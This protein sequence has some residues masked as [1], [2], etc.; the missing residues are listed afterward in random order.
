MVDDTD[1][2]IASINWRR[3]EIFPQTEIDFMREC[4]E[5]NDYDNKRYQEDVQI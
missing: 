1:D 4:E 2:Y 5:N 3:K